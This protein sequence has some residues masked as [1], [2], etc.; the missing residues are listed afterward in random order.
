MKRQNKQRDAEPKQNSTPNENRPSVSD[1]TKQKLVKQYA[2]R[3]EKESS[4]QN[5]VD[6]GYFNSPKFGSPVDERKQIANSAEASPLRSWGENI[7]GTFSNDDR[8]KNGPQYGWPQ[9]KNI[10]VQYR[11]SGETLNF[12]P[13]GLDEYDLI[14]PAGVP[15]TIYHITPW[16]EYGFP[17]TQYQELRNVINDLSDTEMQTANPNIKGNPL[18]GYGN[19][20]LSYDGME[21]QDPGVLEND[22][23]DPDKIP[24]DQDRLDYHFWHNG[25]LGDAEV[26]FRDMA[27]PEQKDELARAFTLL[28]N[29]NDYERQRNLDDFTA[30]QRQRDLYGDM[31]VDLLQNKPEGRSILD[32]ILQRRLP[33]RQRNITGAGD[34]WSINPD[35]VPNR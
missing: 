25:S 17:S 4:K 19:P 35:Y 24:E 12:A 28:R 15:H 5:P 31:L 13:G 1:E 7:G 29:M 11:P 20:A 9:N 16:T 30:E 23:W 3:A 8:F 26:L 21:Y 34:W 22:D 33:S 18:Y 32:P 14:N 27:T 6:W 10:D 2:D